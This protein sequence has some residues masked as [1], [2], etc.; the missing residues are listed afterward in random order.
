MYYD[1]SVWNPTSTFPTGRTTLNWTQDQARNI[2]F[3]TTMS[4]ECQITGH[5]D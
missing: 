1:G 3:L 5:D 4:E 2:R